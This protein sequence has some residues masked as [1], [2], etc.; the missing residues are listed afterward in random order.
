MTE[1]G[2]LDDLARLVG[3]GP[4]E[5]EDAPRI[6][7]APL[8]SIEISRRDDHLADLADR[9]WPDGL[10]DRI[11]YDHA[12]KRWHYWDGVRWRPDQV[13]R[14]YELLRGRLNTWFRGTQSS[15]KAKDL[16]SLL[17]MSKKESVLRALSS[18]AGIG[19]SGSEWDPDSYLLGCP[20]GIIDLRDGTFHTEEH[21]KWLV[22][23]SVRPA[24]DPDATAPLFTK[25]LGE[26]TAGNMELSKYLMTVLG[27]SLFASQQEQKFWLFVGS[28]NNGKGVL[29]KLVAWLLGDY[30]AFPS[31]AL[32]MKTRHGAE[33]SSAAR[34]DL[35]TL[36]GLRF[37]P[38]SEP[39]GGSF[40]DELVKAHTGDDPIRARALYSNQ[41][42]EFRPTHTIVFSTNNPPRVEDVGKSMARRVRVI[43]FTV[44]FTPVLDPLLE[45]KL[46]EEAPG[47]L[48]MLVAF[49][50]E[51]FDHGLPEP[52]AV[53][54]ASAAYIEDN[55]PISGFVSARCAVGRDLRVASRLAY[56]EFEEWARSDGGE[57][58][59][60][61]AFG[62]AMSRRFRKVKG[63]AGAVYHGVGLLTAVQ[64]AEQESLE[65]D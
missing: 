17:D 47:I 4:E 10:A 41:E 53:T 34:A 15:Q 32:Y 65:L 39:T 12:R 25:F 64:Q 30:A 11:R 3:Q 46:R 26:I 2:G 1:R 49:A 36:Q 5:K 29:T 58:I 27:Y 54:L 8:D 45:L 55:D 6:N 42:I 52:P 59:T 57:S 33:Q 19:L 7:G 50:G 44:D 38:M 21:P 28:G 23:R 18:R 22:T 48:R 62:I 31:S 56:T 13:G 43:N 60:Q 24:Y 14:V 35:I 20:N 51:W 63:G 40:N 16:S 9:P 37:T 61:T